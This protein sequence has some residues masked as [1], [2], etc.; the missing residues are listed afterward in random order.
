MPITPHTKIEELPQFLTVEEWRTFMR[1]SRSLAYDLIR[2]GIVPAI[3]WG[4]TVRIPREAVW[5][6]L[7]Q[8]GHAENG[9]ATTGG[10]PRVARDTSAQRQAIDNGAEK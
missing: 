6:Y 10:Q 8:D 2:R 5:K 3:R 9:N 1:I 4:R 7:N